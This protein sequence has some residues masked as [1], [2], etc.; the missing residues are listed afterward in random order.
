MNPTFHKASKHQIPVYP[1]AHGCLC[2]ANTMSASLSFRPCYTESVFLIGKPTMA[3][4]TL[5]VD[6]EILQKAREAA[7]REHT[8]VNALVRD[9]LTRYVDARS[10]RLAALEAFEA[11]AQRS[12]SSS[13]GTWTRD[14]L[15][16]R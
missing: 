3:N 15:H 10:R 9:Y 16:R 14:E 5:S 6:D 7:L 2:P 8:S 13:V 11:V 1:L 12:Q 4:L